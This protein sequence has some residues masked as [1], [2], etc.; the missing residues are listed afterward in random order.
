MSTPEALRDRLAAIGLNHHG[1]FPIADW[2]A[3]APPE[4][5]AARLLPA[6]RSV[7]VFASAGPALWEAFTAAIAADPRTLTEHAHPLDAFVR[8]QVALADPLLGDQPRRWFFVDDS[9]PLDFRRLATLAGLGV[10]SRMGLLIHPDHGLWMGLRAALLLGS[11]AE[12]PA[13]PAD[14]CAT[15]PAPCAAACV[16]GAFDTGQ[17]D[18]LACARFHVTATACA[19]T[20]AARSA[21][22]VGRPYPE[23]AIRYHN[24][25]PTGR[26]ELR[27]RFG[28]IDDP[29][30][31]EGPHWARWVRP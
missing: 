17:L 18:I 6:A 24:H 11:P 28:I 9:P 16:G 30:P 21:C 29:H 7:H 25:R 4:R 13:R 22:P 31:G 8:A 15:C 27:A 12:G 26:A 1:A 14:P 2:D 10:P 3:V 20:C 5:A 19:T 23:D